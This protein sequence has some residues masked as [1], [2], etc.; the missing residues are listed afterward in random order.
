M[1]NK[2]KKGFTMLEA[3]ISISIMTLVFVAP[4]GLA[5]KMNSQF[6]YIQKKVIAN[7]LSQDG[8]EMIEAFRA[9]AALI[10]IRNGDCDAGNMD[11]FWI[12]LDTGFVNNIESRCKSDNGGCAIDIVGV[13]N[14]A[15]SV[16][17]VNFDQF[18]ASS[19]CVNMYAHDY[20]PYT[21]A[22]MP[23]MTG[24]A[25]STYSRY[26]KV[27]RYNSVATIDK[28]TEILVTSGVSF[29]SQGDLKKVET[30]VILKAIN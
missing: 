6:D 27:E 4:L 29:Y 16:G 12:S 11:K 18:I 19:N 8:I 9:N 30:K 26:I 22:S 2:F 20:G 28:D 1:K 17:G 21:C 14:I 13:H 3:L 10:C 5:F 7:N 15:N 23:S 24:E 25:T